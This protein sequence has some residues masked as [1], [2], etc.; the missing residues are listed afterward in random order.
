M[1]ADKVPA[2]IVVD[3]AIA[4]II[5][6][7]GC[8]YAVS[9]VSVRLDPVNKEIVHAEV[10]VTRIATGICYKVRTMVAGQIARYRVYC[11]VRKL[12]PGEIEH[13]AIVDA[14]NHNIPDFHVF[15]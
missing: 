7:V 8:N 15:V 5:L 14:C 4:V 11:P 12:N 9:Q 3:I 13:G 2:E 10:G 6:A 1:S